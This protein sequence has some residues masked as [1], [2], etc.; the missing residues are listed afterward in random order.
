MRIYN[1][2]K[3]IAKLEDL[4]GIFNDTWI[5]HGL[6]I[7]TIYERSLASNKQSNEYL[8]YKYHLGERKYKSIAQKASLSIKKK[9]ANL[10]VSKRQKKFLNWFDKLPNLIQHKIFMLLNHQDLVNF[11]NAYPKYLPVITKREYWTTL[12]INLNETFFT[13]ND[14][15]LIFKYL[16]ESLR[17]I[18]LEMPVDTSEMDVLLGYTTNLTHLNVKYVDDMDDFVDFIVDNLENLEYLN[19]QSFDINDVHLRKL[20]RLSKLKSVPL[21]GNHMTFDGIQDYIMKSNL[22]KSFSLKC[23]QQIEDK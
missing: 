1:L 8:R 3:L 15:L 20:I 19:C 11:S 21:K 6:S 14:L 22:L 7:Q 13:F 2:L 5:D 12:N 17:M 4:Y 16:G 10:K 18:S 23:S 9:Y